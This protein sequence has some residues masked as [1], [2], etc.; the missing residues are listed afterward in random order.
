MALPAKS[1]HYKSSMQLTFKDHPVVCSVICGI[2]ASAYVGGH[3]TEGHERA[4]N[5][6]RAAPHSFEALVICSYTFSADMTRVSYFGRTL[7]GWRFV[8]A[9]YD[10]N[11]DSLTIE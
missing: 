11:R 10:A 4:S 3:F 9:R 1:G 8:T 5:V 7:H 6:L 2:V